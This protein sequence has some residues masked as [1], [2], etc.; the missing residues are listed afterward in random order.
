MIGSFFWERSSGFLRNTRT[1]NIE[2]RPLPQT[3]L[4]ITN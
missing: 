2:N 1:F 4:I 3:M